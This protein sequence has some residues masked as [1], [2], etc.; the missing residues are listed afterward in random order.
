MV[1]ATASGTSI[2]STNAFF[3]N[4]SATNFN[5][6]N[7]SATSIS[8]T[9]LFATNTTFVSLTSTNLYISGTSNFAG[10]LVFSSASGTSITSSNAFFTNLSATNFSPANISATSITSTNLFA[11]SSAFNTTTINRS[12]GIGTTTPSQA[13][14][15]VGSASNVLDANTNISLVTSSQVGGSTITSL[16]VVGRYLYITNSTAATLSIVDVTNPSTPVLISTTSVSAGPAVV[17]VV[18]RYAFVSYS[19]T[20][21]LTIID[22]SNPKTPA[23]I[24]TTSMTSGPIAVSGR[25]VYS[26]NGTLSRLTVTDVTNPSAPFSAATLSGLAASQTDI[27]IQGT[28]VYFTNSTGKSLSIVD[29]SNPT[30]PVSV[31]SASLNASPL[32]V[33]VSGRYAYTA[34]ST[35]NTISVIDVSNP[36]SP[37]QVGTTTVG[38]G[39]ERIF[40]SGRYAFTADATSNTVSVVDVSNPSSPTLVKTFSVSANGGTQPR[41]IFV[42]GRYLYVGHSSNTNFSIYDISG[43][44]AT[45]LVAHS[46]EIGNL[47]IRNDLL[48]QG[49]ITVGTSLIVGAGG[50]TSYGGL[51]VF[52]S[53]TGVTSTIFNVGSKAAT[54]TLRVFSDGT[55]QLTTTTVTGLLTYTT[56]NGTSITS[57]NAFFTNLN[58][59]SASTTNLFST[60]TLFVNATTTNLFA[61]SSIFVNL[62]ATSMTSTNLYISSLATLGNVLATSITS[63]N[64]FVTN[65][66]FVNSVATSITS[67]NLF[68]TTSI[69]NTTTI[70]RSLG[71]GT[72]TPSQALSVVGNISN[73]ISASTT[74][75]EIATTS[76]A[77]NPAQI[78]VSG[79]YA[80]TVGGTATGILSVVDLS[81]VTTP[82]QIAT[83]SVGALPQAIYVSGKYAYVANANSNTISVVD[84][85]NPGVPAQIATTSVGT[86]PLAL[87]VSGR[88]AYVINLIS[89][90]MSVVDVLNPRVPVQI[91]TISVGLD[92]RSVY[93]SGRYAYVADNFSKTLKVFDIS[94]PYVPVLAG[95]VTVANALAGQIFVSGRYAYTSGYTF[96]ISNASS[97]VQ[98]ATSSWG[99]SIFV[100]GRYLY[101]ASGNN[102][103][104]VDIS[105]PR[106]PTLVNSS[107]LSSAVN[108]NVSGGTIFISGRY[109]YAAISSGISV[110][111]ISGTEASSLMAHSVEAGQLQVRNDIV[112]QGSVIAGTS[113]FVGS[114]GIV[115]QG[116]LSLAGNWIGPNTN[117]SRVGTVG[118]GQTPVSIFVSGRYAYT[119]NQNDANISI[120]DISNP[121]SPTQISTV[122]V[123]A[124]PRSVFVSG[125]YAYTA[126]NNDGISIVDVSNPSSAS[127]VSTISVGGAP[128]SIYVSGR[129]AY[130]ANNSSNT[131]SVVDVSN[132]SAPVQIATTSV[133]AGP[134]AIY[135]SGRYAYVANNS[136][137]TISVVDVSNPSAPVQIA[138]TSVGSAPVQIYVS[139]RYAYVTNQDSNNISIINIANPASPTLTATVS[140]NSPQ[141]I[142][143]SGRYA[144]VAALGGT[145]TVIDV[146]VPSSPI[147]VATTTLGTSPTGIYVSGRYAYVTNQGSDNVS[148]VD[149]SGAEISS[150]IAHSA[151][152]GNIQSRN[153]I[154]A[155]GNIMAGTSLMVGAGGIMSQGSLSIF[156]S[157]TGVT[158]SIFK[159]QSA[160]SS[161][162]FSV[163]AS[164]TVQIGTSTSDT[165][166]NGY[167]LFVDAGVS[168]TAAIGVNGFIR[169]SGFVAGTTTLDLAELYPL[170]P[171]C[172]QNGNCPQRG[173]VVCSVPNGG[174]DFYIAKCSS[175]YADNSIGIISDNPGFVLGGIDPQGDSFKPVALSGRVPVN[176]STINGD[177]HFGDKLAASDIPG[178]AMKATGEGRTIAMAM[179]DYSGPGVGS[180]IA[181]V[182]VTWNNTLYK[183]LTIDTNTKTLMIGTSSDP[184]NL[185]VFG[186]IAFKR[187]DLVNKFSFATSSLFESNVGNFSGARA[188]TFNASGFVNPSTDN[189]ILSLRANNNSV[190]SVAANG[191][192]HALGNYYGASAVLGTSTNPGDLAERVDIAMDDTV[193]PGDVMMV[194]GSAPDT[195]RRSTG[196][197]E[198]SVAGVIS[199]N[200]TIVVG[201][202]RTDYTAV[203][204]MVGRVP[205]KVSDE[206]GAVS[207]GDLL[208]SASR[209]GYAM[210]YDPTK[211]KDNRVVGI[212]GL[213]L[214][215]L[216]PSSSG[217]ILALVRTGWV[218]NRD[219][220]IK[221]L[222]NNIEQVALSQGIDLDA[223]ANPESLNIESTNNQLVYSGGNL[224]LQNHSLISVSSIIG[225]SNKWRIDEFG[226]LVQRI[227]TVAGDK[228]I[229]SL[230]SS[231]K[232]EIVIS[233]T[234]TLEN[235]S[236]RVMLTDLDQAI[237]DRTVPLKIMITPSGETFGVYV[238]ERSYDSFLVREN[239]NGISNAEFDWTVIA[240]VL[241]SEEVILPAEDTNAP[242]T[243][244]NDTG[245]V[246]NDTSVEE[247]PTSSDPVVTDPAVPYEAANP[248]PENI[249]PVVPTVEPLPESPVIVPAEPTI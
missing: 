93:V 116:G 216:P 30:V 199:T 147:Q 239:G 217:K 145:L 238:A 171:T 19:S 229:Y 146:S 24:T 91:A 72:S 178:V 168:T 236:K 41:S 96:D 123:G 6:A 8:S 66:I 227:S 105:N 128:R 141:G 119:A 2:T 170:D 247:T 156:A 114:G 167:K 52:S 104:A 192:V 92:A 203:L 206:N 18:G 142:Y 185:A 246:V 249:A 68:A 159:I 210:K 78:Y 63:T 124:Q 3:T 149:I 46:A 161:A 181:F 88:Y 125:R 17:K 9:N 85:S 196:A 57:T 126:N 43:I 204:A 73:I 87:S 69:F 117:I 10:S 34:N 240:K 162:I 232:Q 13:L 224:N 97:P 176:V 195:Y 94:N 95:S 61:T 51:S 201:N 11:T 189:Y 155:Q 205:I 198:Q 62:T 7:I 53:S 134:N 153:D 4:L 186:D 112:A 44:E 237:I 129:Y 65:S 209:V 56:A 107:S 148:V 244:N 32:G 27:F 103:S 177:I 245:E 82:V 50:I 230:Q 67:T 174:S 15:I 166:V 160:Q 164:G 79:R 194:D 33:Y 165:T 241:N 228:D 191:D 220:D 48:S 111:D 154:F 144:Y 118:V 219:E 22:I 98:V 75:S 202:G 243:G 64:L 1:F 132:P 100:S 81:D 214:E 207:R 150:L 143:V 23:V 80:Y 213:A 187:A 76:V 12:L 20:N 71:I 120:I 25:H 197:Y 113:L 169:A 99:T 49:N 106:S 193:E 215:S 108:T 223:A 212:I 140:I 86:Y 151:E 136:S 70:N 28:Y 14:S 208:V 190:F 39:P 182:N 163:F 235:G 121:T 225:S 26:V 183:Q 83:T 233:G 131:I 40:V 74:I 110:I 180:V 54:S 58:F 77:A 231:I 130:V 101:S 60:N 127:Q 5:P 90:T 221:K 59:T 37:T 188:F 157:S 35:S 139:G 42:A 234:S 109:A 133:G 115:T 55:I 222:R 21:S 102:M 16:F 29:V 184:Y 45:S 89:G 135:V 173:D 152:V 242:A 158:S 47:Q 84:I 211:D 31:G 172:G 200:P 175:A 38:A 36:A 122:A 138:T 248:V 137:N 218:Y 226:N 179:G